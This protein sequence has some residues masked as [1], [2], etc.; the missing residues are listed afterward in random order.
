LLYLKNNN[1]LTDTD[2]FDILKMTD[3]Y[4]SRIKVVALVQLIEIEDAIKKAKG[5]RI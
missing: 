3:E 2:E 1:Q 4:V 5:L